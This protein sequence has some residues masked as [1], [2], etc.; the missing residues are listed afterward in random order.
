MK[1]T[2]AVSTD[3]PTTLAL[4]EPTKITLT[5]PQTSSTFSYRFDAIDFGTSTS[6][7]ITCTPLTRNH[8]IFNYRNAEHQSLL[9]DNSGLLG[10]TFE[11]LKNNNDTVSIRCVE[12]YNNK[13]Y[14]LLNTY[15]TTPKSSSTKKT[16]DEREECKV[17]SSSVNVSIPAA[18]ILPVNEASFD[19][20]LAHISASRTSAT[21]DSHVTEKERA[22]MSIGGAGEMR[23]R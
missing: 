15:G 11:T 1:I 2:L 12:L 22:D 5:H 20:V 4:R 10:T 8:T 17:N 13:I 14:D 21:V 23:N 6:P 18:T 9:A 7:S 19:S 3:C 16:G